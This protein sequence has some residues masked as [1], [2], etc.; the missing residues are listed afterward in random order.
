[1][2]Q[3]KKIER[4]PAPVQEGQNRLNSFLHEK[5]HREIFKGVRNII[6]DTLSGN[7]MEFLL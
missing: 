3:N 2:Q 7:G 6:S 1:M 5:F 4:P